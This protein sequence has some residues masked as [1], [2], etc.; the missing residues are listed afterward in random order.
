MPIMERNLA[1]LT[2]DIKKRSDILSYQKV[3]PID[4]PKAERRKQNIGDIFENK[5]KC[6]VCRDIIMSENRHH[7]KTCKC[8]NLSVDGGSWYLKRGFNMDESYKE[9]S[10]YYDDVELN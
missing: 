7:M 10:T 3:C 1:D 5:A 9:L 8:G 2:K 4:T 6:L